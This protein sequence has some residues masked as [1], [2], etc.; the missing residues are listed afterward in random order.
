MVT[1]F[2]H[3]L[4]TFAHCL[5]FSW[6]IHNIHSN[7]SIDKFK[8]REKK[9]SINSFFSGSRLVFVSCTLHESLTAG[10]HAIFKHQSRCHDWMLLNFFSYEKYQSI[11][12]LQ[13]YICVWDREGDEYNFFLLYFICNAKIYRVGSIDDLFRMTAIGFF[14]FDWSIQRTHTS[15]IYTVYVFDC[16]RYDIHAVWF[17]FITGATESQ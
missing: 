16:K 13:V 17:D 12:W 6:A 3:Y 11:Q 5:C 4:P 9:N 10:S 8:E 15:T 2:W 7:Y 1:C 14:L